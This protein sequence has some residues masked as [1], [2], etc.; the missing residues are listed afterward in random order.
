MSLA[1]VRQSVT[2]KTKAVIVVH[3]AGYPCNDIEAIV[4]CQEQG[5]A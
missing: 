2:S 4:A 3:F 5:L 1:S